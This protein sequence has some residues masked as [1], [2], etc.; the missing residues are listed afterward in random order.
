MSSR[1]TSAALAAGLLVVALAG[2]ASP[3]DDAEAPPAAPASETTD[4]GAGD[5][6]GGSDASDAPAAAAALM[7][8]DSSLGEIVVDGEGMT[9]Y[10]FDNDTQ[11]GDASTCEGECAANW[12][13]VTTESD[14]PEVEGVTG[15]VSTITGIDGG[16]QVTLN[17]WPLYYFAGDAAAGDVNGQG[18]NEAWWVLSPDGERMAE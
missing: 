3:A 13:A 7:V 9:V 17:G 11:G 10:M 1:I 5:P 16:I 2:C 12:P 15:E 18:V 6:Y 14:A 8:A 4:S